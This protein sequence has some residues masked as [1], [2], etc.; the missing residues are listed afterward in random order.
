MQYEYSNNSNKE[1][2][3]LELKGILLAIAQLQQI[4]DISLEENS[5][6]FENINS[7]LAC[8]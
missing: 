8:A 2:I 5:I 1:N 4:T 6:K 7:L 3:V